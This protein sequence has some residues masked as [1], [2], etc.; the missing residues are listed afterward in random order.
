MPAQ[1]SLNLGDRIKDHREHTS[2]IAGTLT[3]A[4]HRR[5]QFTSGVA[6]IPL[7]NQHGALSDG[8]VVK[9]DRGAHV[10]QILKRVQSTVAA[11]VWNGRSQKTEVQ[12]LQNSQSI[13]YQ[14]RTWTLSLAL[15]KMPC[16]S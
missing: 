16:G 14:Q 6:G 3:A 15:L 2:R 10:H 5:E 7:V 11:A 12:K 8:S 13:E 4:H 1:K 9:D